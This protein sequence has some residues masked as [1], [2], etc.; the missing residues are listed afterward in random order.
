M[1]TGKK[2]SQVNVFKGSPWQAASIMGILAAAYIDVCVR[3]EGAEIK[4]LVPCEHY[5]A[6]LRLIGSR[7][8]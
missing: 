7:A 1:I 5:S 4:L 2:V 8:L 3:D 6:A